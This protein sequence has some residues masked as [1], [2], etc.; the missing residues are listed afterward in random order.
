MNKQDVSK[1]ENA[2]VEANIPPKQV[3]KLLIIDLT[4]QKRHLELIEEQNDALIK[5]DRRR[6][7]ALHERYTELL[8]QLETQH[9]LR[10][11]VLG[12]GQIVNLI[13]SWPESERAAATRIIQDL[14]KVLAEVRTVN[15]QNKKLISNQVNYIEF[16][17]K[18]LVNTH[19]KGCFYG[20]QGH[21]S[22]NRGNVFFNSAV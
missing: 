6:F 7:A 16:M 5:C 21:Q 8:G 11:A 15:S 20:P 3:L 12:T 14:Q 13:A 1:I 17:M 2:P 9:K 22:I 18:V 19:R 10:T 4:Q